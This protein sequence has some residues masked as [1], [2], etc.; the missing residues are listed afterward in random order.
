MTYNMKERDKNKKLYSKQSGIPWYPT[1]TDT[2]F[3][4]FPEQTVVP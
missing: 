4:I 1:S 3:L 2:T